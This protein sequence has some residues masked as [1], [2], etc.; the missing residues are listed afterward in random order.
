MCEVYC[1]LFGRKDNTKISTESNGRYFP[2]LAKEE[3]Y[4]V[5]IE[6]S[7]GYL[8]HFV[9]DKADHRKHAEIIADHLVNWLMERNLGKQLK[10]I[11]DST[12]VN[13]G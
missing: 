1:V 9:P 11:G 7:G 10:T 8:F 2:C 13:T 5:A 4:S 3:Y 6:P 12:N